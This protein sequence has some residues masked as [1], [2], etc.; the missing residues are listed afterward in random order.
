MGCN[1]AYRSRYAPKGAG[2][3]RSGATIRSAHLKYLNEVKV[4]QR[5]LNNRTYRLRYWNCLPWRRA[6]ADKEIVVIALT[7]YGIET[8]NILTILCGD[9]P[10]LQQ[11]LPF[12]VLKRDSSTEFFGSFFVATAL[13][14]YGMRHRVRGSR[15]AARRCG[16]HISS[17]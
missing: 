7:V 6:L 5:W 9:S 1:S 17:A 12:T 15:G 11:L 14:V 10:T 4:K 2:Q 16:P 13:T 8:H 3:Q